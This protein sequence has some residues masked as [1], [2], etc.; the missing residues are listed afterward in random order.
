MQDSKTTV[1]INV[2]SIIVNIVLSFVLVM[3]LGYIGL[4]TAYS[5]SGL[6]SMFLLLFFLR[7]KLGHMDGR[8]MLQSALQCVL[9]A[10]IMAVAVLF[11]TYW[12]E[13]AWDM[14][15][16]MVQIVQVLLGVII[17]A[18]VYGA[19]ALGMR[20]EETELVLSV[21]KRKVGRR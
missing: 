16:K 20:M 21:V 12:S 5:I 9:A 10:A 18:G 11:F 14:T 4:A 13:G 2:L 6:V 19:A 17:G 1:K 3:P 8:R 15:N 7:R